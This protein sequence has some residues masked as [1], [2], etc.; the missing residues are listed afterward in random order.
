MFTFASL[1]R[2]AFGDTVVINDMSGMG[3]F[4]RGNMPFDEMPEGT[5]F[6]IMGELPEG[7]DFNNMGP[8]PEGMGGI[9]RQMPAGDSPG[10]GGR[11]RPNQND[12]GTGK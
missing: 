1:Y 9:I 7:M 12:G 3:R 10:S 8:P 5:N 2:A 6:I 4:A 11:E